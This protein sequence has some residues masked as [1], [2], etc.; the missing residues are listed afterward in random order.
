[1]NPPSSRAPAVVL[2]GLALGAL[3]D[4]L[5]RVGPWGLNALIWMLILLGTAAGLVRR[6]EGRWPLAA[7]GPAVVAVLAV[8][9]MAWRDSPVMKFFDFGVAVAAMVLV[10]W[11]VR[12]VG[13][14]RGGVFE[15]GARMLLGAG[16]AAVGYLPL[17][18][19][20]SPWPAAATAGWR[21]RGRGIVLGVIL[22]LPLLAV[23]GG[24]L[25]S[26]DAVFAAF[27]QRLIDLDFALVMSH[28]L[29]AA[30]CAWITGGWLVGL[31]FT[32][33]LKA[34]RL[35]LPQWIRLDRVGVSLALGAVNVLFLAFVLVQVRFL[36]GGADLIA[37][38]PGLTYAEYARRGFFELV[39]V[40]ALAL[41]VLLL[42]D[43]VLGDGARRGFRVQAG[44]MVLLLGVI[45]VSAGHRL[46]LYQAEYG[47]TEPRLYAVAFMLWLAAVL[48]WFAVTVLSG[49]RVWFVSGAA[50]AGVTLLVTLHGL[51][52]D[53][54]IVR[55]N[56]ALART[57]RAFD[58]RHAARLSADAFP[59][60]LAAWPELSEENRDRI[61]NRLRRWE[62]AGPADWRLWS[63][64]VAG[65]R[66]AMQEAG[67]GPAPHFV[68]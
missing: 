26:A 63:L 40:A 19:P 64:G 34:P 51:N 53:A 62:A 24:L 11:R 28:V 14:W 42:G 32:E 56:L 30:V 22:A 20:P 45:L 38:T 10:L 25:V 46:R 6:F 52:P 48:V 55:Q 57:G 47:W 33:R 50:V 41:P 27:L 39:A 7:A 5:L 68:P 31:V 36:F 4:A 9:G 8:A 61:G 58:G 49:R 3:G 44:L 35:E 54:W 21:A 2:T 60:L 66:R 37:V 12:G 29:P 67:D 43:W 23:F 15:Q 13:C 16:V 1:M 17:F 18:L 65:A 59:A